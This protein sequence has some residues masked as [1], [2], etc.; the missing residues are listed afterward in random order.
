MSESS[1]HQFGRHLFA[2]KEAAIGQVTYGGQY[3]RALEHH[4][5][6]LHGHV[7]P[8]DPL[9]LFLKSAVSRSRAFHEATSREI[10]ASNPHATVALL[11]QFTETV[12]TIVYVADHPSY[13]TAIMENPRNHREYGPRRKKISTIISD[14]DRRHSQEVGFVYSQLSD[15]THFGHMAFWEGFEVKDGGRMSWSSAPRWRRDEDFFGMCDWLLDVSA[16]AEWAMQH[17]TETRKKSVAE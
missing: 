10:S 16:G 1:S 15:G 13:V 12:V 17:F 2:S 6:E 3:E 9:E 5:R 4:M 11:R 8:T 7:A 14:V